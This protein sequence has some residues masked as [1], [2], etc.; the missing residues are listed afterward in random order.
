[1]Q[2]GSGERRTVPRLLEYHQPRR[3]HQEQ[4][5]PGQGQEKSFRK[6]DL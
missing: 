1:M 2:T 3:F 6:P 4:Q 5:M